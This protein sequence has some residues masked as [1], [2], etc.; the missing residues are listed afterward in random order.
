[1]TLIDLAHKLRPIIEQAAQSL[2]DAT[3]L[4]APTLFKHWTAGEA[5]TEGGRRY[6]PATGKLYKAVT[7]H[8]TQAD[9]TPDI[10]PA[11]WAAVS[12]HQSGNAANPI[13]AARGMEYEYGKYYCDPEDNKIYICR[14]GDAVGTITLQ[15]LPHELIGQYFEEVEI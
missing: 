1:M 5:V 11:L 8:T 13:D 10:T 14:R 7:A 2:D 6:Y 4:E 12:L 9:W 15:Y 3:A